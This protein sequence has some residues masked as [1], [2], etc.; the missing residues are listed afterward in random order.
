[1]PLDRIA[2]DQTNRPFHGLLLGESLNFDASYQRGDVWTDEQR[3][4]LIKSVMQA[5]PIGVIFLNFRSW[6]EA[7]VVV[8][9]K[10][11]LK[12][13]LGFMNDEFSVPFAWFADA[14]T[15]ASDYPSLR[16]DANVSLSGQVLFSQMTD[17]GQGRL[18]RNAIAFYETR[19]PTEEQERELYLR[20]NTAGTAHTSEDLLR[21]GADAASRS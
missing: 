1:M 11:R 12:A 3:V 5:L 14:D 20:I 13:L 4:N 2:F 7:P 17:T 9:G 19:F 6:A 16:A 15:E 21:A 8:D 18:K 10:Q